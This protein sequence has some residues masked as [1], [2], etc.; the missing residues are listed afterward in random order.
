MKF[1]LLAVLAVAAT[2]AAATPVERRTIDFGNQPEA[3]SLEPRFGGM[4]RSNSEQDPAAKRDLE[5]RWGGMY[6]S[7]SEQDPAAKR[8][9]EPRW[10][11]MYR[12][13]SEQDPAAKR[14]LEPR[15]GGMY[16][17]NSE[18]DPAAKRDLEP[19]FGGIYRSNSEQDPAAKR[20]LEERFAGPYFS[21]GEEDP[22]SNHPIAKKPSTSSTASDRPS[23]LDVQLCQHTPEV[24]HNSHSVLIPCRRNVIEVDWATTSPSHLI[25]RSTGVMDVSER[26]ETATY[27]DNVEHAHSQASRGSRGA[28]WNRGGSVDGDGDYDDSDDEGMFSFAR[29]TTRD[30]PRFNRIETPTASAIQSSPPLHNDPNPFSFA[31][32]YPTEGTQPFEAPDHRISVARDPT[33]TPAA[34]YALENNLGSFGPRKR[35]SFSAH[36]TRAYHE[37]LS[38]GRSNRQEEEEGARSET[39]RSSQDK[40]EALEATWADQ[41]NLSYALTA[42]GQAIMLNE[43]GEPIRLATS[44]EQ[45]MLADLGVGDYVPYRIEND[46]EEEEEDS[47]FPEVRASVSNIDDPEMPALTFRVWFI[48]LLFCIVVSALNGFLALRYPAPLVTPVLTQLLSYP[49]GRLFARYLPIGSFRVPRFLR[50]LCPAETFSLN[51]GPFNIKEHT[52]IVMMANVSTA[53]APGIAYSLASE[54]YFGIKPRV[55]FDILL[56]LTT[57]MV[58]FGTAGLCRRFLVWPA[59]MIWP[60]NLVYCTLLNTLHAEDEDEGQ[61]ISRFKFFLCVM[62][63]A[64]AWYWLPG[65]LFT[66]L[67]AFS[68]V[69]WIAPNNVVVNQLFG[70]SSGLGMGIFTFDWSQ[71]AYIGSPLVIPWWAAVNVFCGVAIAF[72]IIAPIMYYTNVWD[73]AYLPM[74]TSEVFDRFGVPYNTS[75]VIDST[76]LSLNETAYQSYSP[77]Y[78]PITYATVYGLAFMLAVAVIVHTV[79]YHGRTMARQLRRARTEDHDVHVKLM[80]NYPE[81]PDWWYLIFVSVALALSIV[82]VVCFHTQ[83]PA[84]ALVV[85]VL[86]GFVYVLPAGIV[87]ALTGTQV[88]DRFGVPYNTSAVIDSTNLSL[89]ETAYQSYSPLYLPI[90]YATVYG[91]AFMLAVAVIVHTVLY[92]GRTM[93]RQLRRARTEDHDVHVKLMRNYPEVPD[94]WYLIF[95]SVALALSIVTV[96]CFHTQTPAWA[97]VVAVLV[98]FVYVLPA[99]IV[100]ALTG[101]QISINLIVELIAGY[102][103]PGRPLANMIF[104]VYSTSTVA[105]GLSFVQDLKL[106]HYMKVPPRATFAVQMVATTL[107]SLVQVGVK[108]WLVAEVPDLCETHQHFLLTCP[109]VRV[110]YSASIIWG[111]IGPARQFA[112][113]QLYNPILYWLLAGALLPVLT[114]VATKAF[115]RTPL[116]YVN[117]PVALTG[118]IYMPPATGINFS[119]WFLVSLI[120]QYLLRRHRFRWW[121]KFNFVLSAG[122]DSGTVLCAIVIFLSLSLPKNGRISLDWWGNNVYTR[123]LDWAGV[124]YKTPPPEGFGRTS[125]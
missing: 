95:V 25:A 51:P 119:S 116:K 88:F 38:Y 24:G 39:P 83:T 43:L 37:G 106:G 50:R 81:V 79:L 41:P 49:V 12:S 94:W 72:W 70:V 100:F 19:R 93:A 103:M 65:F 48:G 53:P 13:N 6:R 120:F 75:A 14:D 17:S 110:Y 111:L 45:K 60:Q 124:S 67:S 91:L 78:L 30:Q 27:A 92:H 86:V 82:T 7:N 4:Y 11:G 85:A 104:K 69:C 46:F 121:S 20:D 33:L 57:Q 56:L 31:V 102:A 107:T 47:P 36:D 76:N 62:S 89:N 73:S 28:E 40:I 66:A 84:W 118:A 108:R 32:P 109:T 123:T 105:A 54:K 115:P 61:G 58:G 64:F 122:L 8:D 74:S 71:V 96:V 29:P 9:L 55:G 125:W 16:R 2:V 3:R 68:W 98:G 52:L 77:L 112:V 114:F 18:Q 90:T 26:P 101:T 10:G 99:G 42:D 63:G 21:V 87:F 15:W 22:A 1:S 34:A 35:T 80:R 59:A 117:I 23:K 113:G 97:L 5:P 44:R